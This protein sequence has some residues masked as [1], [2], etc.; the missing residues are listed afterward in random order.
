MNDLPCDS[1]V[2]R[3]INGY[4]NYQVSS[5]GRVRNVK[6]GKILVQSYDKDGYLIINLWK[7]GNPKTFKVHRLVAKEFI[8]NP[9]KLPTVNHRGKKDDNSLE[10]LEWA[11]Y[12]QQNLYMKKRKKCSSLY[13]GVTKR[14]NKWESAIRNSKTGNTEYLGTYENE[15]V[16][17]RVFNETCLGNSIQEKKNI[18]YN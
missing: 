9:D 2:W 7:K 4:T 11:N 12:Q 6:T 15:E 8:P 5:E 17:A 13:K 1:E 14:G 10:N 3:T 18:F 16:A